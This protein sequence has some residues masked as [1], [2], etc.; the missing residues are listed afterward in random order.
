MKNFFCTIFAIFSFSLLS[1]QTIVE[2]YG[3]LQV[4]GSYVTAENGDKISL[5]G[6]SLYWSTWGGERWYN[7]E[8]INY[9]KDDWKSTI[10]RAAMAVDGDVSG[11]Y[12][13]SANNA[14]IQ[15][16][17]VKTVVE[18]CIAEGL[19]VIIDFHSHAAHNYTAKAVEFFA[20]MAELYGDYPNVIYEI[21]NE[22]KETAWTTIKSYAETVIAA[23]R[24]KD[25]DNLIIVGTR[26]WSQEVLEAANNPINDPNVAYTL[27]FY[28]D[29][30]KQ[31]LRD[32]AVSAMNKGVALFI[33]EWGT[34]D[35]SGNGGFNPAASDD[36]MAFA[37]ENHISLCNWSVHN[38]SETAAILKNTSVLS[39]WTEN[40]YSESGKYVRDVMIN[41]NKPC[42]VIALPAHIEAEN[43]CSQHAVQ[44]QTCSEG[45]K[46]INFTKTGSYITFPITIAV[47]GTYTVSYR[48]ATNSSSS[49]QLSLSNDPDFESEIFPMVQ[50]GLQNYN[51]HGYDIELPEGTYDITITSL[52][53]SFNLNWIKLLPKTEGVKELTAINIYPADEVVKVPVK[54]SVQF[55][56]QGFDQNGNPYRINPS[57]SIQDNAAGASISATGNFTATSALG[58]YV[59]VLNQADF[60]PHTIQVEVYDPCP[61]HS[62]AN[63]IEAENF[64]EA[65][66]YEIGSCTDGGEGYALGYLENTSWLT[67]TID[68]P[69]DGTYAIDFRVA[70]GMAGNASMD[71]LVD[72]KKLLTHDVGPTHASDWNFYLTKPSQAFALT[73]GIHELKLKIVSGGVNINWL[74]FKAAEPTAITNAAT[75][76]ASKV[77]PNPLPQGGALHIAQLP[78]SGIVRI[79]T[80]QGITVYSQNITGASDLEISTSLPRGIYFVEITSAAVRTTTKVVVE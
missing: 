46:N 72:N 12:T 20:E 79:R 42:D 60:A 28:A 65:F 55:I 34:C 59:V 26:S 68:V 50:E 23:I 7:A 57:W 54:T 19:Y 47:A 58:S 29:T 77:Y 38:I 16:N 22:P 36:W 1:A 74:E 52:S 3:R 66:N 48:Y 25:P 32:R 33:T 15:K 31:W 43:Y 41:W 76:G 64:C 75:A 56:A 73:A 63:R 51:T 71:I 10:I 53:G 13:T 27:H 35:A 78:S 24:E 45:G 39:G 37:K 14:I 8:T 40:N 17:R 49:L 4:N 69:E 70:R 44:K 61:P 9:L 67:Y 80:L 2:T 21:Y 6:N 18:A 30:H 62:I 11:A 5:C